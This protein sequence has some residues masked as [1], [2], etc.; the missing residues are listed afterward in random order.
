VEVEGYS[1]KMEAGK[2]N[3]EKWGSSARK[4][5]GDGH[6]IISPTTPGMTADDSAQGE[7]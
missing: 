1:L 7:K 5:L 3:E 4:I 6:R 2:A